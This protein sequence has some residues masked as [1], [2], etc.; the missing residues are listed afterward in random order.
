MNESTQNPK[1]LV[2]DDHEKIKTNSLAVSV[3]FAFAAGF[4][5]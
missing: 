1:L 5:G 3:L 2:H 4:T